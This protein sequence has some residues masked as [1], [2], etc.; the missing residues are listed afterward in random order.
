VKNGG[1]AVPEAI[2]RR[3]FALSAT[4]LDAL[5]KPLCDVYS[6][7]NSLEGDFELVER[8]PNP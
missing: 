4:Y 7:W 5:Y 2:I 3:R 8:W 6:I 1:H